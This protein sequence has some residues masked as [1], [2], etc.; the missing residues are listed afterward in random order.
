MRNPVSRGQFTYTIPVAKPGDEPAK[1]C[2]CLGACVDGGGGHA[3]GHAS[4]AAG[5][6]GNPPPRQL[7]RKQRR[8]NE[9]F[10][11]R[12]KRRVEKDGT[13]ARVEVL[14]DGGIHVHVDTRE[15]KE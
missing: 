13:P 14:P 4:P 8:V 11:R 2:G 5:G 6:G 3:H 7:S 9:V 10:N 15:Q 1:L 12:L